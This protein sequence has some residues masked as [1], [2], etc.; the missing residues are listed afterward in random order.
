MGGIKLPTQGRK[1]SNLY[2]S[3]STIYVAC[4][5][6]LSKLCILGVTKLNFGKTNLFM[7]IW[8]ER[9]KAGIWIWVFLLKV[10]VCACVCFPR[11]HFLQIPTL[12]NWQSNT[13][14][15]SCSSILYLIC[16]YKINGDLLTE[17]HLYA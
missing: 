1:E 13:F 17:K 8:V 4:N 3:V 7:I 15:I 5:V 16:I 11:G 6:R 12:N 2:V 9:V 10:C 14:S